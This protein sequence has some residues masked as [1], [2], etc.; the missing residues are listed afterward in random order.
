MATRVPAAKARELLTFGAAGL[1]GFA[2]VYFMFAPGVDE[3]MARQTA[4]WAP[5][6]EHIATNYLTPSVQN[7]VQ[8]RISPPVERTMKYVDRVASPHM[9]RAARNIDR[10]IRAGI[11]RVQK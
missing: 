6:W 1:G 10:R 5:R 11:A 4:R 7:T 3:K 9:A 8:N 2:P